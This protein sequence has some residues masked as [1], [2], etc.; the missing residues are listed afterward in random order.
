MD[1]EGEA[2]LQGDRTIFSLA[3]AGAVALVAALLSNA[4]ISANKF[5]M[6]GREAVIIY[7][8]THIYIAMITVKVLLPALPLANMAKKKKIYM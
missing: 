4:I 6:L 3:S 7:V 8:Y 2:K 1:A 5:L